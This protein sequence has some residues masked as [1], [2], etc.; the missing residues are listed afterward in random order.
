MGRQLCSKSQLAL[1]SFSGLVMW[2]PGISASPGY[3]KRDLWDARVKVGGDLPRPLL[4]GS[5]GRGDR[6]PTQ[7]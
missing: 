7:D 1:G 5:R 3:G 4:S 2:S 6:M